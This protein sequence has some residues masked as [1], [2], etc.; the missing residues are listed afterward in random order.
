MKNEVV[1]EAAVPCFEMKL[2]VELHELGSHPKQSDQLHPSS[3]GK[4]STSLGIALKAPL[5]TKTAL[6]WLLKLGWVKTTHKKGVYMDGHERE[7]VVDYR[8]NSY[9]PKITNYQGCMAKWVPTGE[10]GELKKIDPILQPGEKEIIAVF[11]DESCFH[12]NDYQSSI[13]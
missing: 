12:A 9:L 10:N 4:V 7:D 3:F 5:C 8:Q 1:I 11:Q 2:S 6:R 13:W